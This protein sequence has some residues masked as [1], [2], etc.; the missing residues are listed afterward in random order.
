MTEHLNLS[1]PQNQFY[2][3]NMS[4]TKKRSVGR[5]KISDKWRKSHQIKFYASQ[6]Y[7]KKLDAMSEKSGKSKGEILREL[8]A[9]AKY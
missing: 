5:P 6:T 9:L 4:T 8:V 3:V 1:V 7:T 2:G